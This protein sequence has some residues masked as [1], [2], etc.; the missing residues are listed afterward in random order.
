MGWPVG[1]PAGYG[2][3]HVI[4]YVEENYRWRVAKMQKKEGKWP[5]ETASTAEVQG[6]CLSLSLSVL[7]GRDCRE[8]DTESHDTTESPPPPPPP[9]GRPGSPRAEAANTSPCPPAH[10]H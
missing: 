5:S 8:L 2:R 10:G 6:L 3:R 9:P 1:K 7:M 4:G